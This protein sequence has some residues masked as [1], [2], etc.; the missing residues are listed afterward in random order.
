[1]ARQ[2]IEK[3]IEDLNANRLY[4]TAAILRD[5]LERSKR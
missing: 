3:A 2:K 1:M 4:M 5:I